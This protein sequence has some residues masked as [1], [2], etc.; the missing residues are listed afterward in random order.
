VVRALPRDDVLLSCSASGRLTLSGVG[1][2]LHHLFTHQTRGLSVM[3]G[4]DDMKEADGSVG[5]QNWGISA[6]A[7]L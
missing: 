4:C 3:R 1:T 2:G 7:A 6:I 5:M